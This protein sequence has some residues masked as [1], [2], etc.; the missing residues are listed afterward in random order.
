MIENAWFATG[1][2]HKMPDVTNEKIIKTTDFK[3]KNNKKCHISK[4]KVN[5][6]SRIQMKRWMKIP[7]FEW[8]MNKMP[9]FK[10]K[11]D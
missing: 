7:Y 9:D 2:V 6:S 5:T 10:C 1:I 4:G 3:W 11:S 8:N